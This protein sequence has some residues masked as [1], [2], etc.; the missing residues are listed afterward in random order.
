MS[1]KFISFE[2]GEGAGKSTQ[3]KLLASALK[4]RG[5][6]VILTREPGGSPGAEEIR[7]ILVEGE[8]ERWTPVTETL[9]F[10]AARSDHVA[11]LIAPSL[12]QGKWVVCDRF[13][14]S[15]LVYQGIAR[16]VG[17][18]T[19][20]AL[21]DA[22]PGTIHPDLTIIIDIDP[23][24]GLRR[25]NARQED[26]ESR[27]EKFDAA[28]HD[29]LRRAFRELAEAEGS[30]CVMVNGGRT[31]ELVAADIWQIVEERFFS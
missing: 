8:P 20:R 12:E 10:L 17:L 31:P 16:E 1:G 18:E 28:F 9:L 6:D 3:T 24:I 4:E 21:E 5:I 30:N 25:A 13:S 27:Y 29:T 26:A 19:V 11:R 23:E 7:K 14:A 15:T 2:G 22:I